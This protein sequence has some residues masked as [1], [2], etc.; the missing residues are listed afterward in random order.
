MSIEA[1]ETARWNSRQKWHIRL[2]ASKQISFSNSRH[3]FW[4]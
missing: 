2:G 3:E 4:K 1:I